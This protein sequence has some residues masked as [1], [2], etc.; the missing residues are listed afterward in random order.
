MI[1]HF[2]IP[3]QALIHTPI[4]KKQ[5]GERATLSAAEKRILREEI[6]CITMRGLLQ[7][8]T[9]GIAEYMDGEHLYNQIIFAEVE[10]KSP[11]KAAAIATMV[12]RAFPAPMF[13]VLRCQ[14]N[15]CVN[16]CTK[17]INQTDRSKR[18]MEPQEMTRFF[19]TNNSDPIVNQW[20]DS[21]D[22]TKIACTTLKELYDELA[23]KLFMLQTS[24]EA[25][26]FILADAQAAYGYRSVLEEL[27]SNRKEQK[28]LLTLIKTETQFNAQLR[29]TAKLKEL[30]TEEKK[31]CL[32]LQLKNK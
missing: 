21:L 10:I 24:D 30:Q 23:V 12:Q 13:I 4:T 18:V 22:I 28:N 26:S 17:R 3:P 15:Y 20:L 19:S 11:A 2:N 8:R 27:K 5:F 9:T 6:N 31:L 1:A 32:Y 7:T 25:G 14:T 29:L 16:W